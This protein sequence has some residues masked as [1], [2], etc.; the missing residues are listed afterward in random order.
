MEQ[1]CLVE[2]GNKRFRRISYND[3]KEGIGRSLTMKPEVKMEE[4]CTPRP[5]Q[6]V[7]TVAE[8]R[9]P[10]FRRSYC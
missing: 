6:P 1:V 5:Y 7:S 10:G 9:T 8:S 4:T 2:Y 3:I